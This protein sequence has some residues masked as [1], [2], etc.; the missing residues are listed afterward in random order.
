[1]HAPPALRYFYPATPAEYQQAGV[2]LR[3]IYRSTLR[4]LQQADEAGVIQIYCCQTID[5]HGCFCAIYQPGYI[6]CYVILQPETQ[7][8]EILADLEM[9]VNQV[10]SKRGARPFFFSVHANNQA[11]INYL[12]TH[13]FRR[14]SL[15]FELACNHLPPA[16]NTLTTLTCKPFEPDK[17]EQYISLLDAAFNP[18]LL[19]QG[20]TT[21]AFLRGK[22]SLL[23]H[24]ME[25]QQ[26]DDFFAFWQAEQLVG[27]Y[28]CHEDVIE[29]IA[30]HPAFQKRGYGGM[31][32]NHAIRHIRAVKGYPEA[33]LFVLTH[34]QQALKLYLQHG[35]EISGH[36]WEGTYNNLW[37]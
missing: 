26:R 11:F 7:T 36:F 27:L 18:L 8:P 16:S 6:I 13:C 34:N 23:T 21:N 1:M 3:K 22:D 9:L 37:V 15:G 12:E 17:F 2:A 4:Q 33:F 35:F 25:C 10:I 24:L 28:Y 20:N 29:T 19:A 32:L 31:L 5:T 30:V 14:D